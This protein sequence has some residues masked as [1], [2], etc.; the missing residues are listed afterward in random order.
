MSSI[1]INQSIRLLYTFK[2]KNT[3]KLQDN[4]PKY[5][6]NII[7]DQMIY[8]GLVHIEDFTQFP[9]DRNLLNNPA[10]G[11]SLTMTILS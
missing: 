10:F 8:L 4:I 5:S 2:S 1:C 3:G 6:F 7:K 11:D 9:I